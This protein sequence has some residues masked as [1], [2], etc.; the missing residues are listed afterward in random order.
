MAFSQCLFKRIL[1]YS[2]IFNISFM[3]ATLENTCVFSLFFTFYTLT[4]LGVTLWAIIYN[5]NIVHKNYNNSL[6]RRVGLLLLLMSLAGVPPFLGFWA[7]LLVIGVVLEISNYF[8]VVIILGS[9]TVILIVYL[10]VSLTVI[11]LK[12]FYNL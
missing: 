9:S 2:R 3:F 4:M 1:G 6:K 8:L 5:I 11:T 10:Y 12:Q 7:K